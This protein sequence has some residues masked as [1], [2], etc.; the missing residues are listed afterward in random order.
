MAYPVEEQA[1]PADDTQGE[2]IPQENAI[3]DPE[4]QARLEQEQ[5]ALADQEEEE[6]NG[7]LLDVMKYAEDEDKDLRIPMIAGWKRND[8]YFNNLQKYFWDETAKDYRSLESVVTELAEF[9]G[10]EDIKT[11]NVYRA[12]AESLVAALSISAPAVEFTPDDAEDPKDLDTAAAYSKIAELVS[13]HNHAQLMLVKA[14]ITLYN[15]GTIFGYNYY[16]TD[17]AYGT[18]KIP[19]KTVQ[20][21][22]MKVNVHCASCGE[23]I[24]TEVDPQA[25]NPKAPI[26]CSSCGANVP[27]QI[28]P[29]SLEYVEEVSEYEE[30]P[31]GRSGFDIFG[32]TYVKAPL[33]ARS[34]ATCGYVILRIE[35][36]VAKLKAIYETDDQP[37]IQISAGG[38]D[39]YDYERW[40]RMPVE[41]NG[42]MPKDMT[43]LR[44]A[45][46]R[47][48]YFRVLK[49]KEDA[50]KLVAKYPEGV[51][52]SVVGD[53]IVDKEVEE[54]DKR[55][56]ISID[57]RSNFIHAEPAGDA[58]IPLQDSENDLF[59][60]GLQS[61]EYGITETFANPKT[62]NFN[63]YGKTR[64]APGMVSPAVPPGPDKSLSDGFFQTKAATLSSEYSTFGASL[65]SK[66]QFISGSVPSIFGGTAEGQPQ[67]ATVYTESRNRALQRLQLTWQVIS[68]FWNDLIYKCVRDFAENVRE[69]Q[70][71]SNK[72]NGTF[73]NVWIRKSELEGSVGHVEPENNGQLPQSWGQKKDFIMSLL[74]MIPQSPEL[75]AILLNPNNTEMLK[76]ITGMPDF[77]IPGEHD[78]DK[79][80]AEYFELSISAPNGPPQDPNN[81]ASPPQQSSIQPDIHVDDHAVHMQVLKN[82]LV[83]PIGLALYK[84][85]PEGYQNCIA[86]YVQHELMLQAKTMAPAGGS[87]AGEPPPTAAQSTQ[88]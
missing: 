29:A 36:H 77:Y 6:L 75:G 31:K 59:N 52:I 37:D 50:A 13:R 18:I 83:S 53:Q 35:E 74:S 64:N 71:Y 54:L 70:H 62:L 7:L 42:T 80:W 68:V 19:S 24:D 26:P 47:P 32:P 21:P 16:K 20:K 14:L 10:I 4:E 63:K 30:T 84:T 15:S 41:Y 49:N 60:L 34:Q 44:T 48:W 28:V 17:P 56:T 82:I 72:Q 55:W 40:G 38:G 43:T 81:P 73:V 79:Q 33:Y 8:C 51:M 11:I 27:P 25:V 9:S 12:T 45:W 88:G 23:T 5:Q 61:I 3:P 58:M 65:T 57:P 2:N 22:V 39:T 69:D 1:I 76:Q 87:A 66:Q 67:T 86:H 46:F 85:N 78:R